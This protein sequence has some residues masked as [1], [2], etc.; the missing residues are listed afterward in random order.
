MG[1]RS[2]EADKLLVQSSLSQTQ[3]QTQ[4][5]LLE[6]NKTHEQR[7]SE[8]FLNKLEILSGK[9]KKLFALAKKQKN[10]SNLITQQVD[11]ESELNDLKGE[12]WYIERQK[13]KT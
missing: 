9:E 7:T 3:T 4:N 1:L 8:S 10:S 11:L 12:L 13:L 2:T 5:E 6:D